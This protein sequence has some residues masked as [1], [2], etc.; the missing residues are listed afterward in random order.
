MCERETFIAAAD[1]TRHEY[2]ILCKEMKKM[3][4]EYIDETDIDQLHLPM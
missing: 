3:N 4:F 1:R 2:L